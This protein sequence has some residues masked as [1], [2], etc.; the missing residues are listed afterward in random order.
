MTRL[1]PRSAVCCV[2]LV[3][4]SGAA[5]AQSDP[6]EGLQGATPG[7]YGLCIAIP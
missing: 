7:L 3:L 4:V 1:I 2:G 5:L 6:C